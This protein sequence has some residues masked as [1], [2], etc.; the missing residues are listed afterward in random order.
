MMRTIL[1]VVLVLSAV[2]AAEASLVQNGGPAR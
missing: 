2:T 1:G